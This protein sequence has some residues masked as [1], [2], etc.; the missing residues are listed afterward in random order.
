MQKYL[1][2]QYSSSPCLDPSRPSP[3]SLT[4]PKG[5]SAAEIIPSFIPT[6]KSEI[7]VNKVVIK[8]QQLEK[9]GFIID[10]PF[11][12]P[13]HARPFESEKSHCCKNMTPVH[14]ECYLRF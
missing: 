9:T 6:C 10:I 8:V 1:I 13:E 3:L 12:T 11:H 2:L 4:P 14:Y 7:N 5:A